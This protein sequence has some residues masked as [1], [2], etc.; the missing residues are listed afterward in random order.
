MNIAQIDHLYKNLWFL[1]EIH[2]TYRMAPDQPEI[3]Y[4]TKRDDKIHLKHFTKLEEKM[5]IS[6]QIKGEPLLEEV[7]KKIK[8]ALKEKDCEIY[9]RLF[10]GKEDMVKYLMNL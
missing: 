2:Y 1:I 10:P 3:Y 5:T 7:E 6:V 8:K 9:I 4:L